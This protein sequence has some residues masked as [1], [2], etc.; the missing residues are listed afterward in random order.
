MN[1]AVGHEHRRNLLSH[2]LAALLVILEAAADDHVGLIVDVD[3]AV[4]RDMMA[5][6]IGRERI[7]EHRASVADES[8]TVLTHLPERVMRQWLRDNRYSKTLAEW[9]QKPSTRTILIIG[10]GGITLAQ[11][12]QSMA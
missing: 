1:E 12:R 2:N 7:E 10:A 9:S 3:D 4:G 5:S 8:P 6:L 11:M